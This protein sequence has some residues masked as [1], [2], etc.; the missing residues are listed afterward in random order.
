M[1]CELNTSD[2]PLELLSIL[3][4]YSAHSAFGVSASAAVKNSFI[5][6]GILFIKKYVN[7]NVQ[8]IKNN[9]YT[10]ICIKICFNNYC[11]CLLV[12]KK[13]RKRL[14]ASAYFSNADITDLTDKELKELNDEK[15]IMI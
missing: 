12:E 2:T 8:N 10:S 15:D 4:A 9:Q 14:S 1:Y 3:Y 13:Y 11:W 6:D 7:K 5:S